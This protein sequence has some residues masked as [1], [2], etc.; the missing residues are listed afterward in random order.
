MAGM[1]MPGE[2]TTDYLSPLAEQEVR[3]VGD[4]SVLPPMD[5]VEEVMNFY[6]AFVLTNL[7]AASRQMRVKEVL[8]QLG[9]NRKKEHFCGGQDA[10]RRC[11]GRHHQRREPPALHRVRAPGSV[12]LQ[13]TLNPQP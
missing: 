4:S 1:T 8:H 2:V 3:Y 13:I 10:Q 9:L 6:A 12:K 7:D 5:S 11:F